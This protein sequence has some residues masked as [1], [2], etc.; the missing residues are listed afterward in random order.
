MSETLTRAAYG[1]L[2]ALCGLALGA[3][4]VILIRGGTTPGPEPYHRPVEDAIGDASDALDRAGGQ[5]DDLAGRV[6]EITGGLEQ[7][8]AGVDR[9]AGAVGDATGALDRAAGGLERGLTG[10]RDSQAI[11]DEID[12]LLDDL[13]DQ[14]G[15]YPGGGESRP[16]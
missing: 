16:P 1:A 4:L 14:Y 3:L 10:G 7:G 12:R 11:L 5:L 2:G 8:R 15:A 13:S 6:G 9:A